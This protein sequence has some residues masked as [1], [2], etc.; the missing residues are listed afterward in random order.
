MM[1]EDFSEVAAMPGSIILIEWLKG[2]N[3]GD[4][5]ARK[6]FLNACRVA[7]KSDPYMDSDTTK[8]R[9]SR[10]TVCGDKTIQVAKDAQRLMESLEVAIGEQIRDI[11]PITGEDLENHFRDELDGM[12]ENE[13]EQFVESMP[14]GPAI[15]E[16]SKG[17]QEQTKDRKSPTEVR[18]RQLLITNHLM[19]ALGLP[20][21]GKLGE[22]Q[23][24]VRSI[25]ETADKAARSMKLPVG[26]QR[27]Q[28]GQAIRLMEDAWQLYFGKEPSENPGGLFSLFMAELKEQG[29]MPSISS[30]A[31]KNLSRI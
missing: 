10:L 25:A 12:F 9:N 23:E 21:E 16:A 7:T 8:L 15:E 4:K 30:K 18:Q 11:K 28:F 3:L 1:P 27:V 5:L 14:E 13:L 29:W 24:T 17:R 2:K 6:K 26:G 22:W 20:P 31:I 19:M